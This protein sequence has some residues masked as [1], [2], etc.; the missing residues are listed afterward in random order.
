MNREDFLSIEDL[1]ATAALDREG[2]EGNFRRGY[3]NPLHTRGLGGRLQ[4]PHCATYGGIDDLGPEQLRVCYAA[5]DRTGTVDHIVDTLDCLVISSGSED[6]G[7][8]DEREIV[9]GRLESYDRWSR[10]DDGFF[11]SVTDG[12]PDT[13]GGLQGVD[14]D[15]EAQWPV[16]PVI[17]TRG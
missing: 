1:V 5:G 3:H 10:V 9:R 4:H 6:V 2:E 13:V 11:G 12:K 7:D 16:A 15:E 17:R 14:E 8:F